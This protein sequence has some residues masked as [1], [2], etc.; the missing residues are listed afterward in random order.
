M[1][2]L[3]ERVYREEM[4]FPGEG[5]GPGRGHVVR[6]ASAGAAPRHRAAGVTAFLL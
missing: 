1:A 2:M 4:G 6:P 3:S 5:R